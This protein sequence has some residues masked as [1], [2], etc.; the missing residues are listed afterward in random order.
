ML[1]GSISAV[2]RVRSRSRV[3]AHFPEQRLV[4]EPMMLS[5]VACEQ[6]LLFGQAKRAARERVSERRKESL[7]PSLTNF[8]L[9]FAQM[10]G[11]TTG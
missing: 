8:H 3:Q 6:A 10:K 1:I 5:N 2:S 9:Y 7:Q 11:N 4:I